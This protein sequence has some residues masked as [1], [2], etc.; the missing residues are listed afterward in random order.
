MVYLILFSV[1]YFLG[2]V[3]HLTSRHVSSI[4]VSPAYKPTHPLIDFGIAFEV[5]FKNCSFASRV[6]TE[7]LN[8]NLSN[9]NMFYYMLYNRMSAPGHLSIEGH[10]IMFCPPGYRM[11]LNTHCDNSWEKGATTCW[12][13]SEQCIQCPR[14]TYS[15]D[16]GEAHQLTSS[17]ITCHDCPVGGNC[18]DGQVTSKPNFWGIRVTRRNQVSAMLSPILL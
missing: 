2:K 6:I 8:S 15:L 4:L 13:L 17:H 12:V 3:I 1:Q 9:S 7:T 10:F 16:W 18:F 14:K 11:I 5:T